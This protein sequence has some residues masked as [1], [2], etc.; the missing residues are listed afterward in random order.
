MILAVG[1]AAI[2]LV[3]INA[4][5]FSALHLREVTQAV[6]DDATPPG[7]GAHHPAPRPAMRRATGT[8]WRFNTGDFKAGNVTSLGLSQPV[9]VEMYTATST[10]Y[11]KRTVGQHHNGSPTN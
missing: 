8:Q 1:V 2:V 7:P 11:P 9:S 10:L 5:L 3:A 6:V 4:V